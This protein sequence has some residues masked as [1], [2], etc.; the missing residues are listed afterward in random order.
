MTFSKE[1]VVYIALIAAI[2]HFAALYGLHWSQDKQVALDAI[3]GAVAA[4][5]ARSQV[6]PT[7]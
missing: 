5:F 7:V 1:P 4:L 6:T 2:I 3:L